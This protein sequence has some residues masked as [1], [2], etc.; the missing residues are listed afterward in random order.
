MFSAVSTPQR[1]NE[2]TAKIA[3]GRKMCAQGDLEG[4]ERSFKEACGMAAA[5]GEELLE[6]TAIRNLGVL[7]ASQGRFEEAVACY[8]KGLEIAQ[9]VQDMSGE[10]AALLNLG[11][12]NQRLGRYDVA[13]EHYSNGLVLT[14]NM[15]QR[16]REAACLMD[17]GALNFAQQRP[18]EAVS[19]YQ[20]ALN[21]VRE[22]N[23]TQAEGICLMSLGCAFCKINRLYRAIDSFN[24]LLELAQREGDKENQVLAIQHLIA[25]QDGIGNIRQV[26]RLMEELHQLQ[27]HAK[28]A[29]DT[30]TGLVKDECSSTPVKQHVH[31]GSPPP[32]TGSS[33]QQRCSMLLGGVGVTPMRP[34]NLPQTPTSTNKALHPDFH[35]L[36]SPRSTFGMS[37]VNNNS[38]PVPS[39]TRR[40]STGGSAARSS[41]TAAVD[42]SP[43]PLARSSRTALLAALPPNPMYGEE[44]V[45]PPAPLD[46]QPIPDSPSFC[47]AD[48]ACSLSPPPAFLQGADV[49]AHLHASQQRLANQSPIP[50]S[51]GKTSLLHS[52]SVNNCAIGLDSLPA[53]MLASPDR[54]SPPLRPGQLPVVGS[55]Q[56]PPSQDDSPRLCSVWDA[57]KVG[58]LP[59]TF[60]QYNSASECINATTPPRSTNAARIGSLLSDCLP[61]THTHNTNQNHVHGSPSPPREHHKLSA[62]RAYSQSCTQNGQ[63]AQ[64]N[65]HQSIT[66]CSGPS[67]PQNV[68]GGNQPLNSMG[69]SV[70]FSTQHQPHEIKRSSSAAYRSASQ[71]TPTTLPQSHSHAHLHAN[72]TTGRDTAVGAGSTSRLPRTASPGRVPNIDS[73]A[74][75]H[76]SPPPQSK[77]CNLNT[78]HSTHQTLSALASSVPLLDTTTTPPL[79]TANLLSHKSTMHHHPLT[80]SGLSHS[81]SHHSSL[82]LQALATNTSPPKLSIHGN[83]SPLVRSASGTNLAWTSNWDGTNNYN[84]A[85]GRSSPTPSLNINSTSA[86]LHHHSHVHPHLGLPMRSSSPPQNYHSRTSPPPRTGGYLSGSPP[87]GGNASTG[88]NG[89]WGGGLPPRPA[90]TCGPS[91]TPHFNNS[92][93]HRV[94]LN[95]PDSPP[96]VLTRKDASPPPALFKSHGHASPTHQFHSHVSGSAFPTGAVYE[97]LATAPVRFTTSTTSPPKVHHHNHS[98][99]LAPTSTLVTN[100]PPAPVA[101]WTGGSTSPSRLPPLHNRLPYMS[102]VTEV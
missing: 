43:L 33:A 27:Q 5:T 19:H 16:D 67:V 46:Q 72:S 42:T 57:G 10:A 50:G 41:S 7:R 68:S 87:P 11:V 74:Q 92:S 102:D 73:Y 89:L 30:G 86:R 29:T 90:A 64:M 54:R 83:T 91:P 88:T 13:V 14:R 81:H 61:H 36:E 47:D 22:L 70:G 4:A 26:T 38:S 15:K 34:L 101:A 96:H 79:T 40:P 71:P 62:T 3:E 60:H 17:L 58:T 51:G 45:L 20:Q 65:C 6:G 35:K 97:R 84:T 85:G 48:S 52:S 80:N 25:A 44:T 78:S 77:T 82:G 37:A 23:D 75:L 32:S 95:L 66:M 18:E 31:D 21:L 98:F 9:K 94:T 93:P 99:S 8:H 39:S 100:L 76:L 55:T 56:L 63:T 59:S 12:A 49:A 69:T 24:D 2:V 53:A 28:P 1:N